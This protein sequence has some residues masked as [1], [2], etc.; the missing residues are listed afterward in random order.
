M[1]ANSTGGGGPVRLGARLPVGAMIQARDQLTA[2]L[3]DF[4]TGHALSDIEL[5]SLLADRLDAKLVY[6]LDLPQEPT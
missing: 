3:N 4:Q 5:A 1:D 6:V 2:L